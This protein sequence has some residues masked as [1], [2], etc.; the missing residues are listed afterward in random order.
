MT[1]SIHIE[2]VLPSTKQ[3]QQFIQLPF[4]VYRNNPHYVPW[5]SRSMRQIIS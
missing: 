3:E 1:Q 5:F 2:K 4:V